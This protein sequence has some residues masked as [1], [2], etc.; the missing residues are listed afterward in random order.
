M[1]EGA[2]RHGTLLNEAHGLRLRRY[3]KAVKLFLYAQQSLLPTNQFLPSSY[4]PWILLQVPG[5]FFI[6]GD[7]SQAELRDQEGLQLFR[8]LSDKQ[9]IYEG[10]YVVDD[11]LEYVY[12]F[13]MTH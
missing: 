7:G 4:Q 13:L 1:Q 8:Y 11:A 6:R 2:F 5:T 12:Q 9:Q 10:R 3:S